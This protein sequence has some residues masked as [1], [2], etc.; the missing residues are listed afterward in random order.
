MMSVS[1]DLVPLDILEHSLVIPSA[2]FHY[3]MTAPLPSPEASPTAPPDPH[4]QP[5]P[6]PPSQAIASVPPPPPAPAQQ[7]LLQDPLPADD[8]AQLQ[9]PHQSH[10]SPPDPPTSHRCLWQD[11]TVS[12]ADPEGLYNHLCN[13]HIGRKSTNNLCLTCKWKDCG[14]TCAKR[15]HITSHLRVHTPLKPHSCEICKKAFKRPQ[16]LKKH[17]KIHT[18]E[19]HQQHKHSKAITVVDPAYVQ[20]VRGSSAP[21]DKNVGKATGSGIKFTGNRKPE[22]GSF[23]LLP[24]PSPELGHPSVHGHAHHQSHDMFMAG[25]GQA[26]PPWEALRG[27]GPSVHAGSKRSHDY[28][29]V[30]DFFSDM[31][32]R[33][34]NPSYDGRMAERLETLAFSQQHGANS[35]SYPSNGS[36]NPRQVSLDIRTPEELAAV[37]EFLIALGRDVSGSVR[38]HSSSHS[39]SSHNNGLNENYFDASNLSQLGLAGM[40]GVPST[41]GSNYHDGHYS[42][43]PNSFPGHGYPP[44]RS[45]HAQISGQYMYSVNDQMNGYSPPA[46]Y[47]SR[48]HPP[49]NNNNNKYAPGFNQNYHHPTP[50]LESSSPH[51]T[52]STPVTTTPPQIPISIAD[53]FDYMRP[54]GAAPVAHLAAPEYGSKVMRPIVPLKSAPG[55]VIEQDANPSHPGPVEPRLPLSS[56]RGTP[57]NLSQIGKPGSLY[58]LLTSGDAQ[59]RLPPL[60]Y[61]ATSPSSSPGG[62]STPRSTH[63]P[64]PRLRSSVLPSLR[65]LASPPP[66]AR[67]PDS[68]E[69]SREVGRIEL[70]HRNGSEIAPSED[71]RR[72]AE[73]ILNLLVSINTD[74]KKRHPGFATDSSRDV[75]MAA[76]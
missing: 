70:E 66:S 22:V 75:H 29:A 33:R 54:R 38:H 1:R 53:G 47:H 24:T 63:S 13:D 35:V 23:G 44:S 17:E 4:H 34:V 26:M 14:T 74:F 21:S 61:R 18:E 68:E 15:D 46:E 27:E 52:V 8:R 30:D 39:N 59:F 2:Y 19:H 57:A 76:A 3:N 60:N 62:D 56:H 41:G 25:P 67:S 37:N 55:T 6:D 73:M 9:S 7:P 51:S 72:H 49:N 12:Y 32:K 31:K 64:S 28:A 43:G 58:P 71:R 45:N 20:R 48:R 16:D 10:P 11:C 5:Q 42:T 65:T 69:L 36:F 40:P 50:P